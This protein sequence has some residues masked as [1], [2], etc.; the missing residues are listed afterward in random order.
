MCT[1]VWQAS[2]ADLYHFRALLRLRLGGAPTV[3]M[4]AAER[5]VEVPTLL[6]WL[7][8]RPGERLLDCGSA[9][10][11]TPAYAA[12]RFGVTVLALDRWTEVTKQRRIAAALGLRG[13]HAVQADLGAL[14]LA[15]RSIDAVLAVSTIEH[16]AD[17]RDA[18][19]ELARV[20]RPGGAVALSV[21]FADQASERWR[22]DAVYDRQPSSGPVF[23]ERV[24]NWDAVEERLLRT[25][26]L[27]LDGR[28]IYAQPRQH[29]DQADRRHVFPL[30][31]LAEL[32]LS[33][34]WRVVAPEHI[35]TGERAVCCLLLRCS[36]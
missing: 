27:R 12:V 24:Y 17:E 30:R 23:F 3:T 35:H 19:A 29:G 1:A 8:P 7:A 18:L 11:V 36:G 26:L 31:G 25:K 13:V 34:G 9:R 21:P 15:D 6:N 16:V 5:Y 33:R 10:S 22:D 28:A 2:A 20:V 32:W 14:P 4:L